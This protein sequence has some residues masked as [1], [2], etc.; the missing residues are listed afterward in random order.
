MEHIHIYKYRKISGWGWKIV[1]ITKIIQYPDS[2]CSRV[3]LATPCHAGANLICSVKGPVHLKIKLIIKFTCRTCLNTPRT[4][5]KPPWTC[6][7]P[8]RTCMNPCRTCMN[9]CRTSSKPGHLYF[10]GF[11]VIKVPVHL[12]VG[13]HLYHLDQYKKVHNISNFT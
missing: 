3:N 12:V 5:P 7:K 10:W 2:H 4:C 8:P 9:P 6:W 13:W 11:F 1:I